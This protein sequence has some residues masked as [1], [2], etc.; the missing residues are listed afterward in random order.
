MSYFNNMLFFCKEGVEHEGKG[1][2]LWHCEMLCLGLWH[3]MDLSTQPI[4]FGP[5]PFSSF[6]LLSGCRD[7][8]IFLTLYS[9]AHKDDGRGKKHLAPKPPTP[10]QTVKFWPLPF[11]TVSFALSPQHTVLWA[12]TLIQKKVKLFTNGSFHFFLGGGTIIY[13]HLGLELKARY[14]FFFFLS[15]PRILF[16]FSFC[17]SD[18]EIVVVCVYKHVRNLTIIILYYTDSHHRKG[19]HRHII[20]NT[21]RYRTTTTVWC[22]WFRF[23]TTLTRSFDFLAA[24]TVRRCDRPS[25]LIL[26]TKCL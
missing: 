15:L 18:S 17:V 11:N 1:L 3:Q 13:P 12:V 19:L 22:V 5:I 7:R 10:P 6:S 23:I 25:H 4:R 16:F 24:Y 8:L 26:Q 14:F 20:D 21:V 9:T 2:T